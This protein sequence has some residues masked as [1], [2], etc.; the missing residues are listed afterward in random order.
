HLPFTV[1]DERCIRMLPAPAYR[2]KLVFRC[3]DPECTQ[4][5]VFSVFDWEVDALYNNLR[6]KGDSAETA[7]AKVID[8]LLND[9]CGEEKDT[10]FFLGNMRAHPHKFSIV[11]FWSPKKQK[12]GAVT[13]KG[14]FDGF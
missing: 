14:L 10:L 7:C 9:T 4:D 2:F 1:E 6:R 13:Q 11:G 5:H 12:V 8:K 3:D